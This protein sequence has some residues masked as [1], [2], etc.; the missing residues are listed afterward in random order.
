V[1]DPAQQPAGLAELRSPESAYAPLV[2]CRK[3]HQSP[4]CSALITGFREGIPG[5]VT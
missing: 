1:N 4:I 5:G 3:A 2:C